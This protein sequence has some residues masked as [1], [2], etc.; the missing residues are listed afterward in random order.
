MLE[1]LEDITTT[2]KEEDGTRMYLLHRPT[3][4]FEY[5]ESADNVEYDSAA[6][7]EW[8][9]EAMSGEINQESQNPVV[10]CWIPEA[11]IIGTD[12][13]H[14]NTGTWGDMGKNPFAES[15]KVIVKPGK[16]RIY[17]E[18]RQRR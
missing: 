4:N 5:N 8:Y 10:S 9:A 1:Q 6:D 16:Y 18:L 7:S 2:T 13:P 3:E 15:Y 12:K 14:P 11:K 17:Q